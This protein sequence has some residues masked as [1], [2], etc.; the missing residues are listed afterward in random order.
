MYFFTEQKTLKS[1]IGCIFENIIIRKADIILVANHYRAIIMKKYYNLKNI[2]IVFENIRYLQLDEKNIEEFEKKYEYLDDIKKFKIVSTSG[3]QETLL[4]KKL[5]DEI[6]IM[7]NV[8]LFFIGVDKLKNDTK[9][10][11]IYFLPRVNLDELKIFL[12]KMDAGYVGYE[13]K[14]INTKYCASGKIYEY[15]Y[16]ELPILAYKNIPLKC[17]MEKNE[18]GVSGDNFGELIKVLQRN[19]PKYKENTLKFKKKI[20][21][22]RTDN[23]NKVI[24]EIHERIDV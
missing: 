16:E 20:D 14:N 3:Y 23:I 18:V 9:Y 8:E 22:L 21:F 12:K 2:P 6:S 4:E 11:N 10:K 15:I 24:R 7:E 5:I 1:K 19:Y 17:F 13:I